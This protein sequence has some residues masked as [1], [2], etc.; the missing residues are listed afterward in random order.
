MISKN[1]QLIREPKQFI[2]TPN[3]RE[4][5][6]LCEAYNI[7]PQDPQA[8]LQLAKRLGCM[9]VFK[10]IKDCIVVSDKGNLRLK[11]ILMFFSHNK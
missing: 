2:L 3:L 7:D 1:L 6:M 11:Q 5:N 4:F 8:R 9:F 10:S